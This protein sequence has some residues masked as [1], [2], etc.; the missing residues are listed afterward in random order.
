MRLNYYSPDLNPVDYK[1]WGVTQEKVY[2][3]EVWDV[4]E[5]R[6]CIIQAWDEFD[7]L[8][9]NTAIS[10]WRARFDACVEA[11]GGHFEHTL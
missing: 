3:T 11:K 4:G 1:M 8:V 7:Q 6:Q 10:Q 2:K 5:M 9:I